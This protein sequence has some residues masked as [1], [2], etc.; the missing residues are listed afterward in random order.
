[1]FGM[2]IIGIALL[3]EPL[4]TYAESDQGLRAS[5]NSMT[6]RSLAIPTE[7]PSLAEPASASVSPKKLGAPPPAAHA[8]DKVP[9]ASTARGQATTTKLPV[10]HVFAPPPKPEG[11]ASSNSKSSADI[12]VSDAKAL[13][14]VDKAQIA[15]SFAGLM[16]I[17]CLLWQNIVLTRQTRALQRSI[18]SATYQQIVAN[19][20]DINKSLVTDDKLAVAFE[21]FAKEDDA[22]T[23]QQE[24]RRRWLAFWLLNHYENAF[25]QYRLGVL[26]ASLWAGIESDCLDQ[27][28]KPLIA[29]LW[30]ESTNLFSEEF[31]SFLLKAST[32]VA[33]PAK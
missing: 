6:S 33:S 27:I 5:S 25:M 31:R 10:T 14:I 15:A 26:P 21:S 2:A 8:E 11:S 13:T 17:L 7:S 29:K 20:C 19:Y 18:N 9:A 4:Q 12:P 30:G 1:M 22:G 28:K 32:N 24:R 23:P 3:L 16:T